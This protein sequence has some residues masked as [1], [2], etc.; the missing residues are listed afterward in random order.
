[1]KNKTWFGIGIVLAVLTVY[2]MAEGA[3]TTQTGD[4]TLRPASGNVN[5][6]GKVH[7]DSG[8]SE[9]QL[10]LNRGSGGP[11]AQLS[12]KDV[13]SG[14]PG[15]YDGGPGIDFVTLK[16]AVTGDIGFL[17]FYSFD[18][19]GLA[20]QY[21]AFIK[22]YVSSTGEIPRTGLKFQV[23]DGSYYRADDAMIITPEGRVGIGTTNP[24]VPLH[25]KAG[26]PDMALDATKTDS[27]AYLNF[28]ENGIQR[29]GVGL[30]GSGG[31]QWYDNYLQ[32]FSDGRNT[33]NKAGMKFDIATNQYGW[34]TAMRI[35]NDGTVDLNNNKLINVGGIKYTSADPV[36]KIGDKFYSTWAPEGPAHEVTLSGTGK[37]DGGKAVLDFA[38]APEGSKEWLYSKVAV[39]VRAFVTPLSSCLLYVSEQS[40]DR[41][42]VESESKKCESAG[43]NWRVVGD[44]VDNVVGESTET[45][46]GDVEDLSVAVDADLKEVIHYVPSDVDE[47]IIEYRKFMLKNGSVEEKPVIENIPSDYEWVP[48]SKLEE[49][50]EDYLEV[51]G[52]QEE[53][54]AEFMDEVLYEITEDSEEEEGYGMPEGLY[55]GF[56]ETGEDTSSLPYNPQPLGEGFIGGE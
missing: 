20:N 47:E 13:S 37:L 9:R 24:V 1:M 15:G 39:N 52:E 23:N 16:N 56:E 11:I 6:D 22:G 45:S 51:L 46:P 35:S 54:D 14:S 17:H 34:K 53:S 44:R 30:L 55:D 31:G 27:Y 48:E 7:V 43:F 21:G 38:G 2:V 12:S 40:G 33:G 18:N 5:V 28:W 50:M 10:F 3:V 42:V 26:R 29:A 49:H 25:V 41:V 8:K 4:L 19:R 32:F 36:F